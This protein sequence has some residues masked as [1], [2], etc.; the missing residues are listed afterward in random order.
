MNILLNGTLKEVSENVKTVAF[1]NGEVKMGVV[2]VEIED[3][4]LIPIEVWGDR[5]LEY[6]RANIG[7]K[8]DFVCSITGTHSKFTNRDGEEAEINYCRLKLKTALLEWEGNSN[9]Y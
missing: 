2:S 1:P 9:G 3:N 7:R 5:K 6:C 8:G 4:V